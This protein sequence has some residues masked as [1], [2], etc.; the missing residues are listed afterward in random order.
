MQYARL[1][2]LCCA[3]CAA[4]PADPVDPPSEPDRP[5]V[6]VV[7]SRATPDPSSPAFR[8]GVFDAALAARTQPEIVLPARPVTR[9]GRCA[10]EIGPRPEASAAQVVAELVARDGAGWDA[11]ADVD[12]SGGGALRSIRTPDGAGPPVALDPDA[13]LAAVIPFVVANYDLFGLTRADLVGARVLVGS[14]T[15]PGFPYARGFQLA[16]RSPV[17][18]TDPPAWTGEVQLGQDGTPWSMRVRS[19]DL[20]PDVSLCDGPTVPAGDPR[21]RAA[22][23]GYHLR[24]DTAYQGPIDYGVVTARDVG[25]VSL[26]ERRD[27]FVVAGTTKLRLAYRVDVQRNGLAWWFYLDPDT[28]ELF[29][30]EQRFLLD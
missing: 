7:V 23:V 20:L 16:G 18:S 13:A 27:P 15:S 9:T 25:A 19:E 6:P 8:T 21:L 1:W 29:V 14:Q 17:A 4:D 10:V 26:V 5:T 2:L 11:F 30:I 3:A 22:V 24:G 12:R 28:A